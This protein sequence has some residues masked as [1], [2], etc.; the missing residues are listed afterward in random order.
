MAKVKG[1]I[2]LNWKIMIGIIIAVVV[3]II[4]LL[5]IAGML[6]GENIGRAAKEI[7]MLIMSKIGLLAWGAESMKLCEVFSKG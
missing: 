7:C 3:F 2:E 5:L 6:S 4:S 1:V